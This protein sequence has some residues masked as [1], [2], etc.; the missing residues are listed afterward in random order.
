[1]HKTLD[2]ERHHSLKVMDSDAIDETI[3]DTHLKQLIEYLRQIYITRETPENP[4][5]S[6]STLM[7]LSKSETLIIEGDSTCKMV[8]GFL[9]YLV[10]STPSLELHQIA[11][12]KMPEVK[13]VRVKF[14][15]V[16]CN[17]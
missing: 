4:F 14:R 9:N 1:M 2:L 10:E 7:N 17:S 15:Y 6:S 8:N 13:I 12:T 11:F 3:D 16:D 5:A